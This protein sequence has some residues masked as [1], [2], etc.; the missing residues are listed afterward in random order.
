MGRGISR[1]LLVAVCVPALAGCGSGV[2]LEAGRPTQSARANCRE[3]GLSDAVIDY[4]YTLARVDFEG[5]FTI[6]QAIVGIR[7]RCYG[8]D[9]YG[10]GCVNNPNIGGGFT[11]NECVGG[12]SACVTAVYDDVYP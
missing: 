10:G 6:Q 7:A 12:C 8:G 4:L 5:G 11:I 3:F 2:G 9:A 1:L